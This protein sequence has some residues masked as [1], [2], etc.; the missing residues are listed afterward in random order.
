M[1]N[2][3]KIPETSQPPRKTSI[4]YSK[5]FSLSRTRSWFLRWNFSS[6]IPLINS[7]LVNRVPFG[8]HG[9]SNVRYLSQDLAYCLLTTCQPHETISLYIW[10]CIHTVSR[11]HPHRHMLHCFC[12]VRFRDPM[13]F[14]YILDNQH[15]LD[16]TKSMKEKP[17]Q[18]TAF[19]GAFW[20]WLSKEQCSDGKGYAGTR[21]ST[22][23]FLTFDLLVRTDFGK[24]CNTR[25]V[26]TLQI[27][28]GI[29]DYQFSVND[30]LW[31][32]TVCAFQFVCRLPLSDFGTHCFKIGGIF[33]KVIGYLGFVCA[34]MLNNYIN[35]S[36][37]VYES[38]VPCIRDSTLDTSCSYVVCALYLA[39]QLFGG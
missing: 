7:R 36:C 9:F 34:F 23:W 25:P 31:C 26:E 37:R 39:L 4:D 21:V 28:F 24:Q 2:T 6:V 8:M 15:L 12:D 22:T 33:C 3:I 17:V 11:T 5:Y 35:P 18:C 20:K 1:V 29:W 16:I 13:P 27:L 10:A 30:R 32:S 14:V 19:R 38:I